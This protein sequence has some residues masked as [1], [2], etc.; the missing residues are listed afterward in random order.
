MKVALFV[1]MDC[2]FDAVKK[3]IEPPTVERTSAGY[4]LL[5]GRVGRVRIL[6]VQTG[7]GLR[8]AGQAASRILDEY[9]ADLV[10]NIGI[11][12]S[13]SEGLEP[14]GLCL[15]GDTCGEQE[16]SI[17]SD[18]E[19]SRLVAQALEDR[20][21]DYHNARLV[22]V[23]RVV[24]ERARK[25]DLSSQFACQ[26]VDMEAIA[27]AKE[28]QER[29]IPCLPVKIISDLADENT[30]L[31]PGVLTQDG[32]MRWTRMAAW[33]ASQPLQAMKVLARTRKNF[34]KSLA[35]LGPA[36]K[37]ILG[38]LAASQKSEPE[39]FF[40]ESSDRAGFVNQVIDRF[41][42]GL[43]GKKV[44]LKPNIVSLEGYPSTTHPDTLEALITGLKALDCQVL[45][46]DAA[47]IDAHP[48]EVIKNHPLC[49]LSR[50]HGI[51]PVD[52]YKS[53]SLSARG[54]MF[55][56]RIPALPFDCDAMISLPVLKT[57]RLDH[58]GM[59]GALKNQFGL[60]HKRLRLNLHLA[61]YA[62]LP[63][64]IA[65]T[66][67]EINSL[68]MPDLFIVDAIEV[69]DRANELRHGGSPARLG[70]MFAGTDPVATD[71]YGLMLL[72]RLGVEKLQNRSPLEIEYLRMAVND[73]GLG[74]P[75]YQAVELD[76]Q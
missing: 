39:V 61:Y 14:G 53:A 62:R 41:K 33:V 6:L 47:A 26:L 63:K 30:T 74:D 59:T 51:E 75:A 1:A 18:P 67:A 55:S 8:R 76:Q 34:A 37:A 9:R 68:V 48:H 12:G 24:T 4:R 64:H 10:L 45:V 27:I 72:K 17:A 44:L 38:A 40:T 29:K 23:A 66:I 49:A 7:L 35:G 58:L 2:E 13:L 65:R 36:T 60:L 28:C 57:H 19:L 15:C 42:E 31:G 11:A 46:G 69:M 16:G 43:R 70:Q 54:R 25:Q 3:A 5:D 20:G 52:F 22:S 21:V 32:R 71:A 73:Y 56:F 50:T